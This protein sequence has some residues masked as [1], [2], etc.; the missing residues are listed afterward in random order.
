M[1]AAFLLG[2][3]QYQ[4]QPQPQSSKFQISPLDRDALPKI[5]LPMILSEKSVYS[6]SFT[7]FTEALFEEFDFEKACE[8]ADALEKEAQSD[9][10]LKPHAKEL[11]RAALLYVFEVQSRLYKQ[12]N[13]IEA[14]CKEHNIEYVDVAVS[15]VQD[16]MARLGLIVQTDG[17]KGT[18]ISIEGNQYDVKGKIHTKTMELMKRTGDL[19]R[20]Y[21]NQVQN[22]V[23]MRQITQQQEQ[24]ESNK[25]GT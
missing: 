14:F 11:R 17:D 18:Q 22:L 6:D 23:Q 2:R 21:T 19:N 13:D 1:V 15:E 24:E 3:S 25:R 16:N 10:L 5:A 4:P 8:L 12:G 20:S 7:Q 9:I